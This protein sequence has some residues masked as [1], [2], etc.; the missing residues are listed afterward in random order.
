MN[1]KFLDYLVDVASLNGNCIGPK[2]VET[3]LPGNLT[4]QDMSNDVSDDE[5]RST[6]IL[7]KKNLLHSLQV[8]YYFNG[9][10]SF[11]FN[12][13]LFEQSIYRLF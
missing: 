13:I 1:Y 10:S 11:N 9:E 6:N 12:L 4:L 8:I 7:K 2:G 5:D 3:M